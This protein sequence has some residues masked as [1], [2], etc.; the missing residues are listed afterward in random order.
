M[1]L[2][3]FKNLE[4][5]D[6]A[7]QAARERVQ[8]LVDKFES[9]KKSRITVTLEMENSPTQAGPDLFSVKLHVSGGAYD[10]IRVKKSD[11][12][13][14]KALADLDDHMLER[15]NRA[16]DRERV[17][18]RARARQLVRAARSP[19]SSKAKSSA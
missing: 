17:Q 5:S 19:V 1:I 15:F 11:A 2:V 7:G 14:Y 16:S 9:L 18:Q 4:K 8:S 3:K 6:L 13:L 10:G 12:N